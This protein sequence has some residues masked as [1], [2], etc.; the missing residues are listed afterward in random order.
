[1]NYFLENAT[2]QDLHRLIKYKLNTIL[3][4][5]KDI[6]KE[7]KNRINS[8]V[9]TEIPKQLVD[10]KIIRINS[11]IIGCV[12]VKKYKDGVLL[13][14]IYIEDK[15]RNRG[16][17]TDIVKNILKDNKKVYLFVYK[18]NYLAYNLYKKLGF[19]VIESTESRYFMEYVGGLV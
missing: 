7:E 11:I 5:A 15:Y 4:Y 14:E 2:E 1:M 16:I 3:E 6:S 17:G 10:Y 19:L 13:D 8:Y 18:D 9:N 12:L